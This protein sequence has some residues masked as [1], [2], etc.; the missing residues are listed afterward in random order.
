VI[1]IDVQN[2]ILLVSPVLPCSLSSG[3]NRKPSLDQ[4]NFIQHLTANLPCNKNL[5]PS[6]KLNMQNYMMFMLH[7]YSSEYLWVK[8]TI[9]A[10][11]YACTPNSSA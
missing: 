6:Q 4:I 11:T 8:E 1:D 7:A 2:V 9:S 3:V 5:I 10:C